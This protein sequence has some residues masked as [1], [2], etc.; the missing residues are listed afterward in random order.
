[1]TSEAG[2][3]CSPDGQK[4]IETIA[5]HALKRREE[6]WS[7]PEEDRLLSWESISEFGKF[8]ITVRCEYDIQQP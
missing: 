3:L 6:L 5:V 8:K 7:R 4:A 1:M 2:L